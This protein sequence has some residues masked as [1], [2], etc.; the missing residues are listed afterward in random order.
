MIELT[1]EQHHLLTQS[2]QPVRA[3]DPATNVEYVLVPAEL[4]ERLRALLSEETVVATA[5]LVDRVMA[6]DDANDPH[7]QSYQSLS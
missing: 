3:I 7:L 4:Y 5:E 6:E 2:P 1:A